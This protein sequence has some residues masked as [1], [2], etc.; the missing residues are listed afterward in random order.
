MKG[1]WSVVEKPGPATV[2]EI[3]SGRESWMLFEVLLLDVVVWLKF[4]CGA[5]LLLLDCGCLSKLPG[6]KGYVWFDR[7]LVVKVGVEGISGRN[8]DRGRSGG[9]RGGC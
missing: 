4:A 1:R 7:G 9:L 3:C 6:Y 2:E 5:L 8:D